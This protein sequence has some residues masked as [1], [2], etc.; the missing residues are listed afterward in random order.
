MDS[1][2]DGM[3]SDCP[4]SPLSLSSV[5]SEHIQSTEEDS[6]HFESEEVLDNEC[7][8]LAFGIEHADP[9]CVKLDEL[10]RRGIV[11]R[12]KIFYRYLRDIVE[13]SINPRHEYDPEVV[14]FFNS[15]T[16]LGGRR[17]ANF[18]RGPMHV[19]QGQGSV[20]NPMD[21]KMNLGGPSEQ[22][23]LKRQAGYT[24]KSGVIKNLSL[25]HLKMSVSSE[26]KLL[27]DNDTVAVI[28]AVLANDGTA[29]KPAIEFDPR[30]KKNV[31]LTV[32]ADISFIRRNPKPSPE[33][34]NRHIVSEVLVSSATTLDNSV[35]LPCAVV[36][37]N[38]TGK[39]GEEMKELFFSQC[40][41]LQAC[42]S[43]QTTASS[44]ENTFG[45]GSLNICKSRCEACIRLGNVCEKCQAEGQ[46][47]HLP[48]VRA[49][50]SCVQR[51]QKCTRRAF[52]ALTTDC[53]EGN[54]QAMLAMKKALDEKTIEEDLCLLVPLPDCPHVGKSLKASY[55]NW[56][57][58]LGNERGNLAILRTLRN[59]SDPA[60]KKIMRKLLPKNDYVRS[61]DRQDPVAVLKLTDEKLASFLET[62]GNVGH[63]IIPE[64]DKYT[65]HNQVG[66]FPN[67][68]SV[69]V[70]P[71][72]SLLFTH[73]D[74]ATG[75]SNIVLATL[76]SPITKFKYVAKNVDA[77]EV[78]Y[79]Q[80]VV[81]FCGKA[82]PIGFYEITK[83]AVVMEPKRL[84]S[85]QEV[86]NI[87]RKMEL[88]E[89]GNVATLRSLINQRLISIRSDYKEKTFATN[90]V[91]FWAKEDQIKFSS[92]HVIDLELIY[93]A[94]NLAQQLVSVI[95]NTDG[96]GLRGECK[97]LIPYGRDWHEVSSITS[98]SG[99]LYVA[100]AA[101]VEEVSLSNLNT[102][103]IISSASD[104][105]IVL[106]RVDDVKINTTK[107]N[108]VLPK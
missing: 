81:F 98:S 10:I 62:V 59:K 2:I 73:L 45:E 24:T 42:Q 4:E 67:P 71:F 23:C 29:L 34:L 68:V 51:K 56:F 35:S 84:R 5:S 60:T 95:M 50:D 43:C 64:L 1:D 82:T 78:H 33:F 83:G 105:C 25:A 20:H 79:A 28:P 100:H 44:S 80:G 54:K 91:N 92:I 21:C 36:Y 49:C 96:V 55:S 65:E 32:D 16:Y 13:I 18:I 7:R 97:T 11:S 9:I 101:G 37:T 108:G 93:A 17:T 61:K 87:V 27:V 22:T 15:I 12:D 74:P 63:T 39:S 53:E 107:L 102:T 46:V 69:A 47:S 26:S 77:R 86:L 72:G 8:I 104:L 99:S 76:H 19:Y 52:V 70:G 40:K 85:R 38:K 31:G 41:K 48:S 75:R 30:Q 66:T 88:N 3:S 90:E 103:R 89:V 58:K 106:W 14:E 57:L 94:S 6:D